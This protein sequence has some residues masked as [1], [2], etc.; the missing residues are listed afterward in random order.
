MKRG[1]K[2]VMG[3]ASD[4]RPLSALGCAHPCVNPLRQPLPQS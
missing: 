2:R 1:I 3:K 4:K